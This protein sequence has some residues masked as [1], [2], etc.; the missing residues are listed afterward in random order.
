MTDTLSSLVSDRSPPCPP[1]S[2]FSDQHHFVQVGTGI[3][4]VVGKG[5]RGLADPRLRNM[6]AGQVTGILQKRLAFSCLGGQEQDQGKVEFLL[7]LGFPLILKEPG[8]QGARFVKH[9][10]SR[11]TPVSFR[12]IHLMNKGYHKRFGD[13]FTVP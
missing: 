10:M 2:L 12:N 4:M 11:A 5:R 8:W 9:S 3:P 7:L 1:P 6:T 13:G